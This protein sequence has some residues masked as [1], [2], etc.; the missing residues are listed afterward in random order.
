MHW[1]ALSCNPKTSP[2]VIANRERD[3]SLQGREGRF[4]RWVHLEKAQPSVSELTLPCCFSPTLVTHLCSLLTDISIFC[5]CGCVVLHKNL[6]KHLSCSQTLWM[7]LSALH[8]GV[9]FLFMLED[10]LYVCV[11]RWGVWRRRRRQKRG[12]V[13]IGG[14]NFNKTLL[15]SLKYFFPTSY[16]PY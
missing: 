7:R 16:A 11:K 12:F 14:F 6:V 5:V 2:A 10:A 8:V 15:L 4:N 9:G 3:C 13:S 1:F